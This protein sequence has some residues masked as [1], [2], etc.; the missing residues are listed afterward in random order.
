M[1]REEILTSRINS[2]QE[3]LQRVLEYTQLSYEDFL[4]DIK[5]QDIVE[6]NLFQVI[7]HLISL[8][9]HIAV[10]EDYGIPQSSYEAAGMLCERG[11]LSKDDVEAFRKMVGFRNVIGHDYINMDKKVVYDVLIQKREDIKTMV[12]KIIDRFL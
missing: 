3:H 2:I 6:Y 4:K 8:F 1:V 7:N 10:D 9:Q 11:V 5:V 12:S